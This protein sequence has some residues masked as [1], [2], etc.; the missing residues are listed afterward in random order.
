MKRA[1][2]YIAT[3]ATG[4]VAAVVYA[5]RRGYR[6]GQHNIEA[7]SM[8]IDEIADRKKILF[9]R[10]EMLRL[11]GKTPTMRAVEN[12]GN[13]CDGIEISDRAR[14]EARIS[15]ADPAVVQ[16]SIDSIESM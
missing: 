13:G 12:A 8:T 6:D 10:K 11:D 5:Y 9:G 15:G 7:C 14:E 1:L 16:E 2:T 4:T 3:I